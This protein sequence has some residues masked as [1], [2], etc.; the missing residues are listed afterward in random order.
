MKEA[1]LVIGRPT[2][3]EQKR[4]V[5]SFGE[6]LN[7]YGID[8]HLMTNYPAEIDISKKYKGSYYLD[9]NPKGDAGLKWVR[10]TKY[11]HFE[12]LPNWCLAVTSLYYNGLKILKSLGYTHIYAFN[13]DINPDFSKVKEFID[14]AKSA[15]SSGKKGVFVQYPTHLNTENWEP[16]FDDQTIDNEHFAG[17]VNFLLQVFKNITSKYFDTDGIRKENPAA[18][19][20]HIWEYHLRDFQHLVHIIPRDKA[21]K[22]TQSTVDTLQLG[23]YPILYGYNRLNQ[24]ITFHFLVDNE[25]TLEFYDNEGK[26]NFELIDNH[27][28]IDL[29]FGEELYVSYIKDNKTFKEYLFKYNN[30][31][32]ETYFFTEYEIEI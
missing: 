31:F 11:T 17:N 28:E 29:K 3:L 24:K 1:V 18:L 27:Y 9:Y 23:G 25:Y 21:L 12:V 2:T 20:E 8:V 32:K 6:F 4:I 5:K 22:G 7:Q 10:T 15:F 14:T 30:D 19:C 26:V 16:I 13:Y